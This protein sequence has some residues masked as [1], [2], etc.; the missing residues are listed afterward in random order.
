M[1]TIELS[2]TV[3]AALVAV[4]T[5]ILA[6]GLLLMM[7]HKAGAWRY[8]GLLSGYARRVERGDLDVGR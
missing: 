4:P 5:G 8:R 6:A 7:H 2:E 1:I 3:V